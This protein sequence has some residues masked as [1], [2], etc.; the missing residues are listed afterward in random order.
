MVQEQEGTR[1]VDLEH[2]SRVKNRYSIVAVVVPAVC[3]IWGGWNFLPAFAADG[4]SDANADQNR[5]L[6]SMFQEQRSRFSHI[7]SYSRVQHYS[8]TA[9]RFGLKAELVARVHRDR[10]KNKTYEILSRTG[11]SVVQSHVFDALLEAEVNTSHEGADLLNRENYNFHLIGKAEYAGRHCY[12]LETDP[13][14]KDKRLLKGRLWLDAE[15]FGVVHVEGRP[16]ESLSFWVGRP[17]IM[18]DFQ[19]QAGFWWASR[20]NSFIDNFWLGKSDL[21]IEYTDYQFEMSKA[22]DSPDASGTPI[23]QTPVMQTKTAA[24]P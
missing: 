3:V 5:V 12:L 14:H 11:S 7:A 20:R 4:K 16:A 24:A 9:E 2:G 17:N 21:V 23:M 18:Q 10:A 15:D 22:E 13:K 1:I 6:E 19:K 8:V